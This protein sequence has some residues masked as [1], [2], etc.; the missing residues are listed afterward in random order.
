MKNDIDGL[1]YGLSP[2]NDD[3]DSYGL[4]W[5]HIATYPALA[6]VL[7]SKRDTRFTFHYGS[8]AVMAFESGSGGS[9]GGNMYVYRGGKKGEKWAKQAV[10][11]VGGGNAGTLLGVAA[12]ARDSETLIVCLCERELVVLRGVL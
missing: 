1:L 12:L 8:K 9:V 10:L 7:A 6:F 3:M 11:R 4:R 2:E 5:G